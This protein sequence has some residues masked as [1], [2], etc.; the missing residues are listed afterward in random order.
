M[1]HQ[2][3]FNN[4]I[5]L[6]SFTWVLCISLTV[7]MILVA[8]GRSAE[9]N[10]PR[11]ASAGSVQVEKSTGG[12]KSIL[13]F[14]NIEPTVLFVREQERLLQLVKIAL[15]NNLKA[16]ED[17]LDVNV[18]AWKQSLAM[19]KVARCE[20]NFNIYVPDV[21]ATNAL[22]SAASNLYLSQPRRILFTHIPARCTIKIFTSSGVYVDEIKVSDNAPDNGIVNWDMLTKEGLEI[23]A[24]VYLYYV[25]FDETGKE[26]LGKFAVI[27]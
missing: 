21:S 2:Y 10:S 6:G 16:A 12:C 15:S 24:G 14:L 22:E 7:I 5:R 3:R 11:I 8:V 1:I 4:I 20:S 17:Q 23:T 18:G 26:K 19:A 27:K 13:H 9:F 25:K